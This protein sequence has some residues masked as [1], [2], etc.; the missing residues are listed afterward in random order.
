MGNRLPPR[1]WAEIQ[2]KHGQGEPLEKIAGEYGVAKETISRK[3]KQEGW[4]PH[5]SLKA[6]IIEEAKEELKEKLKRSYKEKAEEANTWHE[7]LCRLIQI[8]GHHFLT[9]YI[10]KEKSV[11]KGLVKEF[12][13]IAEAVRIGIAGEREVLDLANY[14]SER[15]SPIVESLGKLFSSW[16]E[17]REKEEIDDVP[18]G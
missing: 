1:L 10:L 4:G 15:R 9:E 11:G 7:L 3:A 8:V 5:G 16:K 6:E 18:V 13:T 14:K 17:E 12:K 2:A